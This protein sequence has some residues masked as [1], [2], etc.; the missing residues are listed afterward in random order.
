MK[1]FAKANH[2]SN[3][4]Q[5]TKTNPMK[6]IALLCCGLLTAAAMQAQIIYVHH[7]SLH[8]TIQSGIM[9]QT[10]AIPFLY[11]KGHTL[12]KS[13]SLVKNRSWWQ[14]GS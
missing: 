9:L 12:N 13:T 8:S 1:Y 3:G 2:L 6:K 4:N 11:L 10:L 14:A 7:D 5:S